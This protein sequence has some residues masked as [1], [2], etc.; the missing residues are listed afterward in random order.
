MTAEQLARY[1]WEYNGDRCSD[2][3]FGSWDRLPDSNKKIEIEF[4]QAILDYIKLMGDMKSPNRVGGRDK[5][6]DLIVWV[7]EELDYNRADHFSNISR[8]DAE[9]M[10][11]EWLKENE[12]L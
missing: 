4:A 2:V 8:E 10:L 12:K 3:W 9:S 1:M 6:I 7:C 11:D 5:L